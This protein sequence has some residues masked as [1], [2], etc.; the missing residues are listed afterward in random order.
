MLA[1]IDATTR[2]TYCT[3][4]MS[5]D[6]V[7]CP[8]TCGL[9]DPGYVASAVSTAARKIGKSVAKMNSFVSQNKQII[10]TCSMYGRHRLLQFVYVQCEQ[11]DWLL[12]FHEWRRACRQCVRFEWRQM[13]V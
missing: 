11:R 5:T 12:L 1:S 13:C 3:A 9:C 7:L 2:R 6:R 8:N 10:Y 4:S